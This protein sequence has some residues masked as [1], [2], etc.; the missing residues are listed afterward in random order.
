M[1]RRTK[2][3]MQ[4][5][6]QPAHPPEGQARRQKIPFCT[7]RTDRAKGTIPAPN[8]GQARVISDGVRHSASYRRPV[9]STC[10]RRRHGQSRRGTGIGQAPWRRTSTAI[11][12]PPRERREPNKVSL[13]PFQCGISGA[14]AALGTVRREITSHRRARSRSAKEQSR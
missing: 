13:A 5:T 12:A 14:S 7:P 4:R 1:S 3:G 11:S 9:P 8:G 6:L 2:V 10:P